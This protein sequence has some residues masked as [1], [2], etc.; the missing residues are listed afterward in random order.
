M[1]PVVV[2]KILQEAQIL[3]PPT[4]FITR[5]ALLGEFWQ[6]PLASSPDE[7]QNISF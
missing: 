4:G 2:A 3:A 7:R 5:E 1:K 6:R